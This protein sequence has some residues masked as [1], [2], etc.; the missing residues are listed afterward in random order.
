MAHFFKK[1]TI[2]L[3]KIAFYFSLNRRI[4]KFLPNAEPIWQQ[5]GSTGAVNHLNPEILRQKLI[6]WCSCSMIKLRR[7]SEAFDLLFV[8]VYM[9]STNV[10]MLGRQL[11]F[12]F[13]VNNL[14][15]SQLISLCFN[16]CGVCNIQV[17]S[18]IIPI[19]KRLRFELMHFAVTF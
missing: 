19:I 10:R 3:F 12:I 1:K 18:K 6:R 9:G 8:Q 14:T 17:F 4:L 7:A 5:S 13:A 11:R 15:R 2:N 16:L